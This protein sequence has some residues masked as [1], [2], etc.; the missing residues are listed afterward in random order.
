MDD[1]NTFQEQLVEYAGGTGIS[2]PQG[3]IGLQGIQGLVGNGP[4]GNQGPQGIDGYQGLMGSQGNQGELGIGSPGFQGNQ[5]LLGN[6]GAQG[7]ASAQFNYG[8][9][10]VT[11]VN[12]SANVAHGLGS[13]PTSALLTNGDVQL[14]GEVQQVLELNATNI[15]VS[16]PGFAAG[17]RRVN[18][19]AFK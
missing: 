6:Q 11:F 13:T 2:G 4:A 14:G 15:V 1:E 8:S 12:G 10:L 17:T 9:T 3:S 5:G 18:W 16:I 7:V 19:I